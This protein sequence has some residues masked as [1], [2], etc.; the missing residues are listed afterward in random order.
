[1]ARN[2]LYV[3][4]QT[5]LFKMS[6]SKVQLFTE[7]PKCFYLDTRLGVARLGSIPFTLNKKYKFDENYTRHH[8]HGLGRVVKIKRFSHLTIHRLLTKENY[9]EKKLD[10]IRRLE[11]LMKKDKS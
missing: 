9:V 5:E 3:K 10:M 1:M 8:D 11:D 7:C 4:N 2:K 6:R